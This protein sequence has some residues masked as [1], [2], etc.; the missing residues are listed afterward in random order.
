MYRILKATADTYITDKIIN[1]SFRATDANVGNAGTIDLFK[2]Y[3]ESN[4][5]GSTDPQIEL[6]RALIKFDL[7]PLRAM[8]GSILDISNPTFKCTL[9]MFDVYGGQPT[10]TNFKL[11]LFPLSQS[12]DEGLGRDI[13]LFQDIDSSNFITASVALSGTSL[14]Y[15]SGAN[16]QGLLGSSDI[17]IVSSGTI[18]GS[19]VD[20]WTE[21][22]FALG[23]EDLEMNITTIVSATIAGIL[24]DKGFRLSY[25]GTHETDTR[26][27][28]VKRFAS[29]HSTNTRKLPQ[30]T[31][32]W[33]DSTLDDH[34]GMFF[35]LTGSLFLNNRH[36]LAPANI[37]SGSGLTSISGT[38]CLLLTLKT[39]SFSV[40]IT[41]S[42]HRVGTSYV[43]GVY[44]ASFAITSNVT[45][46]M[47]T[48]IRS[49]GSATFTEIWSSLDGTVGYHTGTLVMRSIGRSSFSN[50]ISQF[51]MNVQNMRTSYRSTEKTRFRVFA[52]DE[53]DIRA[54][55][56]P[57]ERESV[58]LREA[59]Y[60]IRDTYTSDVIIPFDTASYSTRMSTDSDGMYF[61]MYMDSL[62]IGRVYS[63]DVLVKEN[64]VDQVFAQVGGRFRID[65]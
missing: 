26:S 56:G 45:A 16:R 33:D 42:Q 41:G 30:I 23:E 64:G 28:F 25:S 37:V 51:T 52:F 3:D 13:S 49:A 48:E 58:T 6:S 32:Q 39:G 59:F 57:I 34:R 2:L 65:P 35:D 53:S 40:S 27:R 7:N 10:P 29:R 60:Q 12:F 21:Q 44:S 31:V 63:I 50:G 55:R 11:I 14:W 61:D 46:S 36:R 22:R 1:S 4:L 19:I 8:T 54:S 47:M 24:P 62:S 38:N 9:R 43:T 15:S 17:D 20:L 5:S 18:N